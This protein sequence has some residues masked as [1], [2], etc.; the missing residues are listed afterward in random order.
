MSERKY[1]DRNAV[2]MMFPIAV[3]A[4]VS[5]IS[6]FGLALWNSWKLR[7]S[8]RRNHVFVAIFGCFG[9]VALQ[10]YLIAES[11]VIF[12]SLKGIENQNARLAYEFSMLF[13]RTFALAIVVWMTIG[14]LEA[15]RFRAAN[16]PQVDGR[17]IWI[18]T[19]CVFS[20]AIGILLS[21]MLPDGLL[22]FLPNLIRWRYS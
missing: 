5:P 8:K 13:T 1:S 11:E 14:Q 16:G 22:Q 10:T 18:A 6:G 2:V 3:V 12:G 7:C 17:F 9:I 20:A 21:R 15:F 19:I 4:F